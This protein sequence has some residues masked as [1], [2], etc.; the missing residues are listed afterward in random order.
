M[1]DV[2]L[3]RIGWHTTTCR[4]CNG[5]FET[6][7][8]GRRAWYCERPTCVEDRKRKRRQKQAKQHRDRDRR[9]RGIEKL[10][11]VLH[12][13]LTPEAV[14]LADLVP[15][16]ELGRKSM[17]LAM[18]AIRDARDPYRAYLRLAAVAIAAAQRSRPPDD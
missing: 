1:G 4:N 3:F 18:Q 9:R 15:R 5:D 14:I 11:P 12:A 16:V 10:E 2:S 7:W 6:E 8:S 13:G 17:L